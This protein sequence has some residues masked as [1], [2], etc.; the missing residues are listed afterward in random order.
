MAANPTPRG[1][2]VDAN[3]SLTRVGAAYLDQKQN[4]GEY[5]AVLDLIWPIGCIFSS[6]QPDPPSYG[7]WTR[8]EG[9]F[10]VGQKTGDANFGTA[11]AT[12]GS[13]THKHS[14]NPP[15]TTSSEPSSS[16]TRGTTAGNIDVP[17]LHHT[18][19]VDIAAFDSET[20]S[21]LPP[22]KAVY[23]WERIA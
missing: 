5:A 11:G 1:A 13:K 15:S 12:G 23:I 8:I 18:H 19:N 14:I 17:G 21:N 16:Q 10:L 2:I 20:V 3:G 22:W 6:T 7:T 4:V 9:V